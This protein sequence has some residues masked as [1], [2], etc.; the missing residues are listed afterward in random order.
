MHRLVNS[1]KPGE[2]ERD[3]A[4]RLL[5]E[6]AVLTRMLCR[7]LLDSNVQ[8]NTRRS[9]TALSILLRWVGQN[10]PESVRVEPHPSDGIDRMAVPDDCGELLREISDG[11]QV[12]EAL[13]MLLTADNSL[14]ADGDRTTLRRRLDAYWT[15]HA[16]AAPAPSPFSPL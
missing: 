15:N 7:E 11:A 2:V 16:S 13:F 12:G 10:L 6:R 8:F 3:H 14:Q 9:G 5:S 4:T 1:S